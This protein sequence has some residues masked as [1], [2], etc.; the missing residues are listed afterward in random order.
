MTR[1]QK[2]ATRP[3]RVLLAA[4]AAGLVTALLGAAAIPR[5]P[6]LSADVSGD[7][8][9]IDTV[10]QLL[11]DDPGVRDR[12]SVAVIDGG[13]VRT[14]HFGAM[15][16]TEYEIGSVTKTITGSLLADAI[17]RGEVRADTPLGDLLDLGTSPAA[18]ITLDELATHSSGL[19]R[20]PMSLGMIVSAIVSQY[21]ASDPYGATIAEL[22]Q[23]ARDTELGERE[24]VYSNFGFA[25]LGQ[26]LAEAAGT[27]YATLAEER[28][29]GP[30]GMAHSYVP[31]TPAGLRDD[32]PTGYSVAG[33]PADAWTLGADAPAGSARS[34]LADMI[35]YTIAQRDGAAP[36]SAATEPMAPAGESGEVGYAWLTTDGVTWHNGGTGGFTSWVGFD[37]ESDRAV[38]VLNGTAATVDDLGFGLMATD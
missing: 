13:T 28:V 23:S 34:T 33:R 25:L 37:R 17:E 10:H 1:L 7:D 18:S 14:A 24:F 19:P 8:E 30:L 36:G 6:S 21:R 2:P 35:A 15:D 20:L 9:L 12:L 5:P 31:T 26:A 3:R 38:V 11:A 32:A 16:A 27:D 29:L 22:E 4:I